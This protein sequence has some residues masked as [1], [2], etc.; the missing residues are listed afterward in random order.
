[1]QAIGKILRAGRT[2]A[3][4]FLAD[5][6][7][8]A[9]TEFAVIVPL[10][11]VMF[12]GTVEFSSA[13]AIDRKVT[14]IA[15][16]LSD[17]TSQSAGTVTDINLQNTFTASMAIISP[18]DSTLVTGTLVQIYIDANSIAKIQWSKSAIISSGATQATLTTPP[19]SL[20]AGTTVTS[21]IPSTLL[22]PSTYLI[23]SQVSYVYTPSVMYVLKSAITL[24]DVSYTRP[25]QVACIAY[26]GVPSSC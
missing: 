10:M 17:L 14:L 6:R 12:F 18:Y 11:L 26:N 7:A 25:R 21:M 2:S 3:S 24:S 13:V 20:S 22:L 1:M 23:F 19:P 9:A 15:R 8:L 16:T 5:S 4:E